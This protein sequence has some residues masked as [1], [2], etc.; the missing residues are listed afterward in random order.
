MSSLVIFD[1]KGAFGP[2]MTLIYNA[3]YYNQQGIFA[4]ANLLKANF[5]KLTE[6]KPKGKKKFCAFILE[7]NQTQSPISPA[8]II[9][10]KFFQNMQKSKPSTFYHEQVLE[11]IVPG[12]L[13]IVQE[14]IPQ[15]NNDCE[16]AQQMNEWVARFVESY[17]T[18]EQ[19]EMHCE[20]Q[21]AALEEIIEE[22]KK[23][24][25]ELYKLAATKQL[26]ENDLDFLLDVSLFALKSLQ[27]AMN[28]ASTLR[29]T[30]LTLF[31]M[32]MRED[33]LNLM[34]VLEEKYFPNN[35]V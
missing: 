14:K 22:R 23:L 6:M 12:M 34:S 27:K 32:L 33:G 19:I 30:G 18:E 8:E 7:R 20:L 4:L 1:K 16:D 25:M 29:L 11:F 10:T 21:S 28:L 17:M 15:A 3:Q 13:K 24:G 2:A 9:A 35:N 26:T 5:M 31:A